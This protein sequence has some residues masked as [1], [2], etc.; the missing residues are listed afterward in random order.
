MDTGP[1]ERA[2][3]DVRH[4][5]PFAA[6][7]CA[8][9]ALPLLVT[10]VRADHPHDAFST[11]DAAPL[12][13]LRN[14]CRYL[15]VPEPLIPCFRMGHIVVIRVRARRSIR[16]ERPTG[17]N[18]AVSPAFRQVDGRIRRSPDASPRDQRGCGE[19]SDRTRG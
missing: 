19:A 7:E 4:A 18:A 12:T 3:I 13:P 14:R 17:W 11:D 6:M 2:S 15:H 1:P 8:A 5:R 9:L 10:G 16:K